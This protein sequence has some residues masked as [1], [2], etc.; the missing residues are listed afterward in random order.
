[1]AHDRVILISRYLNF[2]STNEDYDKLKKIKP[3]ADLYLFSFQKIF[4]PG[5][6]ICIDE[7]LMALRL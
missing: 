1:M 4:T 3:I 5:K 7:S 2:S 6:Y